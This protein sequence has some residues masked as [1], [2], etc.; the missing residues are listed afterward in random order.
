MVPRILA[1]NKANVATE[2]APKALTGNEVWAIYL[3]VPGLNWLILRAGEF[4]SSRTSH[5]SRES[6]LG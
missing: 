2:R 1:E 6:R 5:S 4:A 3:P